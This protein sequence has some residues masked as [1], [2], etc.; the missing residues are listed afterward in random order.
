M[1]G[2]TL[3]TA[4]GWA[5]FLLACSV[6]DA[7]C[8]VQARSARGSG[9]TDLDFGG[10]ASQ[11]KESWAPGYVQS[12]GTD[13]KSAGQ[14]TLA[15]SPGPAASISRAT[16]ASRGLWADKGLAP[17]A[18]TVWSARGLGSNP[19]GLTLS[20]VAC[21][22]IPSSLN[23]SGPGCKKKKITALTSGGLKG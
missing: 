23:R 3:L 4:Q 14:V 15:A 11:R 18:C 13:G 7:H 2:S 21:S 8:H 10:K 19:A 12:P 17:G 6:T 9:W 16:S 1:P 22:M 20:W 5:R